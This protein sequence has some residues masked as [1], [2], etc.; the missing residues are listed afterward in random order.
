[1]EGIEGEHYWLRLEEVSSWVGLHRRLNALRVKTWVDQIYLS[2]LKIR[3][4]DWVVGQMGLDCYRVQADQTE[5]L[6]I[7]L[8][9]TDRRII[10]HWRC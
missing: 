5:R 1:M 8:K 4:Y 6:S 3:N 9:L 2:C 7:D 10:L